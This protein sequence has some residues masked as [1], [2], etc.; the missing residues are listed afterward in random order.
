M[1]G[2][3]REKERDTSERERERASVFFVK[4]RTSVL[5]NFSFFL[6]ALLGALTI[7]LCFLGRWET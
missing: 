2:E 5:L 7:L 6:L 4:R 1:S 3:E